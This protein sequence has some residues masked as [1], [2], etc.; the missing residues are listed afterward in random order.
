MLLAERLRD[1]KDKLSVLETIEKEMK[2]E[3][4]MEQYY[5]SGCAFDDELAIL[6]N[7]GLLKKSNRLNVSKAEKKKAKKEKKKKKRKGGASHEGNP[8]ENADDSQSMETEET[9]RASQNE[10]EATCPRS[11][12]ARV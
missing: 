8:E 6:E 3:L 5:Q 9:D 2:L 10:R 7:A 12:W 11:F 4:Q 1:E